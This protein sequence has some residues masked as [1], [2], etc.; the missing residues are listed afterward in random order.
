M[1]LLRR[2]GKPVALGVLAGSLAYSLAGCG[3]NSGPV[4]DGPLSGGSFGSPG[5]SIVCVPGRVGQPFAFGVDTFTNHGHVTIMLDRVA[6]LHP[7]HERLIGSYAVPGLYMVGAVHWPPR[8]PPT[9]RNWKDRQPVH[10]FR[11][12]PGKTFNMVLG[13]VATARGRVASQ[14][15]RIYYRGTAGSSYLTLD[16][17]QMVIAA[18]KRGCD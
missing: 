18:T 9:S 15:M 2:R 10:G 4:T 14:G 11:L 3:G 6:L 7:R 8:N 5:G 13:L 1:K 16:R 12:A 17:N